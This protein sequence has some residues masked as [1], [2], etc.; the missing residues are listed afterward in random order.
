M[1]LQLRADLGGLKF[2]K[3][4][5]LAMKAKKNSPQKSPKRTVKKALE[6]ATNSPVREALAKIWETISLE[7]GRSNNQSVSIHLVL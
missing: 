7:D 2:H 5:N 6:K 3:T 4:K 1:V